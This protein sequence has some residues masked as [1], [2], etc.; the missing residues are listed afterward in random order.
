MARNLAALAARR[1]DVLVIGGGI[2]G[3]GVARDAA[4][5]ELSVLLVE[6][7]D[8]AGGTSSQT[9]K[10]IHGGLRYLEQA[11][12]RLVFEASRERQLLTG[13]FPTSSNPRRFSRRFIATIRAGGW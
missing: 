12:F 13:W 6:Q 4:L 7:G 10:L 9:S 1:V 2:I 5:R 3:A 11:R 8:F